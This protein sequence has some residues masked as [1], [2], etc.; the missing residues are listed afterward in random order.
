LKERE[1]LKEKKSV[2]G[3]GGGV[4]LCLV[5]RRKKKTRTKAA[6]TFSAT[7]VGVGVVWAVVRFK[8]RRRR[9]I[10]LIMVEWSG[11]RKPFLLV[12]DELLSHRWEGGFP[13]GFS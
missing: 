2:K 12:F 6:K 8:H 13:Q 5:R 10:N 9:V 7:G 3:V 11:V 1:S 4:L